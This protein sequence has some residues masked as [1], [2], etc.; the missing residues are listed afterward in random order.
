MEGLSNPMGL[1]RIVCLAN[2]YKHDHRCV[3]GISLVTKKWVRLVGRKVP[4]C[5]TLEEASYPGGKE[6]GLLDVFDAELDEEC[7]SNCHPEDVFVT[8]RPWCPIR[9]FDQPNDAKF[10]I[11]YVSQRPAILQGYGDRVTAHRVE[12]TPMSRSLELICPEDLW[13]WVREEKGKRRSR[14]IF[15]TSPTSRIRYDL[16]V[17]DPAC[18]DVLHQLPTGIHPHTLLL[19][20]QPRQTFLCVSLSEPF[21]GFHYKL[22]AGVINL[23]V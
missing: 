21:Y 17:T 1:Q 22:A 16:S 8:K 4:G 12:E 3:A 10:L 9:R 15:R 6:A 7:G 2:S 14:A 23:P 11:A 19:G 13:W 18:L 20:G 5:L